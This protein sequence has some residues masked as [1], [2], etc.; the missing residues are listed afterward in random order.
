MSAKTVFVEYSDKPPPEKYEEYTA[1]TLSKA[2]LL[3]RGYSIIYKIRGY[4]VNCSEKQERLILS[5]QDY[6]TFS[7]QIDSLIPNYLASLLN[8]R[9][10]WFVGNPPKNWEERLLIYAI[11]EKRQSTQQKLVFAENMDQFSSIYLKK[12]GF[13]HYAVDLSELS[14]RLRAHLGG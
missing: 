5:E 4:L 13:E 3:E 2:T 8:R 12:K 7:R 1:E 9:G 6:F 10:L 14:H 11:L